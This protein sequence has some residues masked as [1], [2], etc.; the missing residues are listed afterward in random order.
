MANENVINT[1][2]GLKIDTLANW[3]FHN[4][5]LLPGE[6]AFVQIGEV[7]TDSNGKRVIPPVMFKVGP[8]NF[9]DLGWGAAKAADVY[10]WAKKSGV[11]IEVKYE[12]DIET[13]ENKDEFPIKSLSFDTNGTELKLI[14]TK[15]YL[16]SSTIWYEG[17]NSGIGGMN[18]SRALNSICQEIW[19]HSRVAEEIHNIHWD[20]LAAALADNDGSKTIKVSLNDSATR[21]E[22][23]DYNVEVVD[24]AFPEVT[25][26]TVQDTEVLGQVI[27]EVDQADGAITPVRKPIEIVHQGGE[28][29]LTING[30][31][32][33]TGFSD[34]D[35]IKDGFLSSVTKDTTT[36]EIVFKWNTD[37]GITE[38][39]IDIDDLVEAYTGDNVTID[40]TDFTISLKDN[41][42]TTDKIA[43]KNVTKAKLADDV[44]AS[45]A[46]ADSALQEHQDISGKADKVA[47]ATNGNFAGLDANGNL[48]DSGKKA[49]DFATAAQ[50]ALADTAIQSEDLATI[51]TSGSIY[52]VAEGSKVSEG[53]DTN[54][55]YLVFNCGTASTV[56]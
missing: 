9:N 6:V 8:G 3:Q 23:N 53:T 7:T 35:F 47:G 37:A 16:S 24:I 48:T 52:D 33:G 5:E 1:R 56:I 31:K 36:N 55:K 14:V 21:Y 39:R 51:A 34:A 32:I 49:A 43:E 19:D 44:Q 18:L 4:P 20:A 40:V 13:L 17:N 29:Y 11:K 2:I 10:D 25:L 26:P 54:V 38:T 42:V 45:L 22:F 27:V 50:G 46:K 28:I 12:E 41:G 15:G 30:T